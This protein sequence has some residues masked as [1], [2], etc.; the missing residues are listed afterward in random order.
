ME[1]KVEL[2]SSEIRII[3]TQFSG[4]RWYLVRDLAKVAQVD[5]Q[6]IYKNKK[7]RN[8][9]SSHKRTLNRLMFT[10]IDMDKERGLDFYTDKYGMD[11]VI[12]IATNK[13]QKSNRIILTSMTLPALKIRMKEIVKYIR[14]FLSI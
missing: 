12:Q 1:S 8:L 2:G 4:D 5:L 10:T 7:F 6:D 11:I 9:H 13:K 3:I 14:Y